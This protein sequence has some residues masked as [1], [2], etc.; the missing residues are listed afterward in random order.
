[1]LVTCFGSG[2]QS[3]AGEAASSHVPSED[4]DCGSLQCVYVCVIYV[5]LYIHI[6]IYIYTS[7]HRYI[8]IYCM[9]TSTCVYIYIYIHKSYT[10]IE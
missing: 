6:Y 10:N 4:L 2:A 1:M 8:Y 3:Q 7:I 5:Y 9:C